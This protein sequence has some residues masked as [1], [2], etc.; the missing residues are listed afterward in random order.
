VKQT[1]V[2]FDILHEADAQEAAVKME[3]WLRDTLPDLTPV[4]GSSTVLD[5]RPDNSGDTERPGPL[6]GFL[7][8]ATIGYQDGNV[9]QSDAPHWLAKGLNVE[10]E[11]FRFLEVRMPDSGYSIRQ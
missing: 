7:V 3:G 2:Y 9:M 6:F 4:G 8:R 5:V 1:F 11:K 10:H